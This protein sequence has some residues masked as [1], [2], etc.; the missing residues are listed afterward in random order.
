MGSTSL[1]DL[2]SRK[3][4]AALFAELLGTMFLVLVACGSATALGGPI[5]I[6][7]IALAFGLSV[8]TIVWAI[9]DVSGG[10][11]NPAVTIGFLVT[12]RISVVRALFYII[13]QVVGALIG[14]AILKALTPVNDVRG[15]GTVGYGKLNEGQAFGVELLITFVLVLTVFSSVDDRR[16][17]LKGSAPLSIGLSIS[18][19]HLWAVSDRINS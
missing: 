13:A 14:A 1:D 7:R 10:H 3:F 2:K 16:I 18:M 4:W 9:A 19:C 8:G 11:I 6:V 5:D 17:N 15:L 12:R